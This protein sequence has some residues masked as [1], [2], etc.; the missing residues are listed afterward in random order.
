MRE[1]KLNWI[2]RLVRSNSARLEMPFFG[3]GADRF[4]VRNLIAS[5]RHV[6][7]SDSAASPVPVGADG[8]QVH[9]LDAVAVFAGDV[10]NCDIGVLFPDV[11]VFKRCL[12]ELS[13]NASCGW[14]LSAL[15]WKKTPRSAW[16]S[17]DVAVDTSPLERDVLDRLFQ[18]RARIQIKSHD[19]FFRVS[20][21]ELGQVF[22]ASGI[23]GLSPDEQFHFANAK[24]DW[25]LVA[26]DL[27][28]ANLTVA[29]AEITCMRGA[30]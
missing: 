4:L 24:L 23:H 1:I 14:K 16:L 25:Q 9:C 21:I 10:N 2:A 8:E 27:L 29:E 7:L 30:E 11:P 5:G 17:G 3:T 26:D 15:C 19:L 22:K 13:A 20:L 18:G 12:Q 28:L 6:R